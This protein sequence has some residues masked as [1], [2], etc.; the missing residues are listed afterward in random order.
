MRTF[1]KG[2]HNLGNLLILV[3]ADSS[4][5]RLIKRTLFDQW[6]GMFQGG[7]RG[8]HL[9][10]RWVRFPSFPLNLIRKVDRVVMCE[11]ANLKPR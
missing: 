3:D 11:V 8:L 1:S 2:Q 4:F 9:F 7:E 10:L 6:G 5:R